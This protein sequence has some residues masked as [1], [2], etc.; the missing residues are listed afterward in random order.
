MPNLSRY[1]T[2]IQMEFVRPH[3]KRGD[4]YLFMN[5]HSGR[6]EWVYPR[7]MG[8]D[9]YAVV[10]S[11]GTDSVTA[12]PIDVQGWINSLSAMNPTALMS[13]VTGARQDLADSR[14]YMKIAIGASVV[15]AALTLVMFFRGQ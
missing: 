7:K 14:M 1:S 12:P 5:P 9:R 8:E 2:P 4:Y 15:A 13:E 3:V 10:S 11:L 6:R